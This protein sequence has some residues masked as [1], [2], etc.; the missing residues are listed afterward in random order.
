MDKVLCAPCKICPHEC[1]LADGEAGF[2]GARKNIGGEIIA[3]SYGKITAIAVDP[4]EKKPLRMFFPGRDI[5]SIGSYGCNF[6]CAFCQNAKIGAPSA[7]WE[8]GTRDGGDTFPRSRTAP[9]AGWEP[10]TRGSGYTFPRSRI[11]FFSPD[12][13]VRIARET[14]NNLGIAYTYNEPLINFEFLLDC[15]REV[16]AAGMKNIV[17]TNG[18]INP[19][20]LEELLPHIDAW[21]IDLKAF[22]PEFYAQISGERA[23]RAVDTGGA[24]RGRRIPSKPDSVFE[25]VKNTI[26]RAQKVD[27]GDAC[28]RRRIPSKPDSIFE[29]VKN[30]ITRAQKIA[31]VEVTTLVIPGE[32]DDDI[33][34]IAQWLASLS[35]EIP[36]HISRF[37]PC[38]EYA[39]RE[40]TPPEK[41]LE[42][43]VI[44]KKYLQNVFC[45]NI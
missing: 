31:H 33:E 35:P 45:G 37:F 30:T 4:I 15:A 18:F 32:N 14:P 23:K 22:T 5:L 44:A 20:P 16:R 11:R 24:C 7:L 6:R 10:G 39:D 8:P 25:C 1:L 34:P 43:Q 40:P 26:T 2:C 27:T 13:L 12:E 3:E 29:C 19:E 38:H 28:Q 21:N 41:I 9:S 17:V 42:L 36:L